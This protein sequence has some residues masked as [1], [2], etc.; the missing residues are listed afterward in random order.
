MLLYS[1][2]ECVAGDNR[3]KSIADTT[4]NR[5][6]KDQEVG[7]QLPQLDVKKFSLF[8]SGTELFANAAAL[9]SL[10]PLVLQ[11]CTNWLASAGWHR[12]AVGAEASGGVDVH[13]GEQGCCEIFQGHGIGFHIGCS[14]V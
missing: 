9:R 7:F 4:C 13:A 3:E 10:S 1:S 11:Q 6:G 12:K 14:L 2:T 8:N 5:C